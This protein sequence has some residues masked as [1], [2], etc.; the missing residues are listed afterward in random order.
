MVSWNLWKL[1][2]PIFFESAVRDIGFVVEKIVRA[3][4]EIVANVGKLLKFI[5]RYP[6]FHKNFPWCLFDGSC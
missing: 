6:N 4:R 3:Y 2:D 5:K 1:R